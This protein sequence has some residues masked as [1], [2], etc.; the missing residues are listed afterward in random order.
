MALGDAPAVP[1][2]PDGVGAERLVPLQMPAARL[3]SAPVTAVVRL[4]T[5]PVRAWHVE[6]SWSAMQRG[7]SRLAWFSLLASCGRTAG[8]GVPVEHAS[9][10][11]VREEHAEA[12]LSDSPPADGPDAT[13]ISPLELVIRVN[14]VAVAACQIAPDWGSKRSFA[15]PEL[16]GWP[17]REV[18]A[19]AGPAGQEEP[20]FARAMADLLDLRLHGMAATVAISA[21]F[22]AREKEPWGDVL[23]FDLAVKGTST[24][25]GRLCR[26]WR[27]EAQATGYVV[28]RASDGALVTLHA[29]GSEVDTEELCA[30]VARDLGESPDPRTCNEGPLSLDMSWVYY[31]DEPLAGGWKAMGGR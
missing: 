16:A 24:L 18:V 31:V 26:Q 13:N 11:V 10:P 27:S 4:A 12:T 7:P 23:V 17:G 22:R 6:L 5:E 8:V 3:R 19:N 25:R 1:Y 20:E 21:R 30:D 2:L 28:L 9:A 14:P 29:K 15:F